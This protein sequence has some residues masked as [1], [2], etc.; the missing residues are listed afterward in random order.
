VNGMVDVSAGRAAAL[1]GMSLRATADTALPYPCA[2]S[3]APRDLVRRAAAGDE[4]GWNELVERYTGL[5]FAI[6]RA[7]RL[8]PAEAADVNQIVWLRLVENLSRLRDPD[9]VGAWIAAVARHECLRVYRRA[10]RERPSEISQNVDAGWDDEP[11]AALLAEERDA[12]LWRALGE[13]PPRCR[14]L[15]RVL[16]VEPR[17]SY[18][19]VA[20]ALDMPIGSIGPTRQRCLERL[21]RLPALQHLRPDA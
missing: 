14:S 18:E 15:L 5:V 12:A 2:V 9:R 16:L 21:R 7:H 1:V 8:E 3:A 17:P 4:G 13:L 10:G 11:D 20:A 6:T 19:E